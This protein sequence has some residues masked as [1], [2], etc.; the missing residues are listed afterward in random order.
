YYGYWMRLNNDSGNNYGRGY[1]VL[2]SDDDVW[3]GHFTNINRWYVGHNG[4]SAGDCYIGDVSET[5]FIVE[6]KT[7]KERRCVGFTAFGR[8]GG[9]RGAVVDRCSIF[10][11]TWA[12]SLNNITSIKILAE[13]TNGIK[14]GSHISIYKIPKY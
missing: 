13:E 9:S 11:Q 14:A 2:Q 7:G 6:A 4:T 8:T 12:N 3:G 10:G 1:I 5:F